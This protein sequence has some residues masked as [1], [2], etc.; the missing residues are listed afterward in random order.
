MSLA[1]VFPRGGKTSGLLARFGVQGLGHPWFFLLNMDPQLKRWYRYYY[2]ESKLITIVQYQ[3]CNTEYTYRQ[4]D[5]HARQA[6]RQIDRSRSST[7]ISYREISALNVTC[8]FHICITY[9]SEC[10]RWVISR[11]LPALRP[12]WTP[13]QRGLCGR[14]FLAAGVPFYGLLWVWAGPSSAPSFL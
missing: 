4:I 12:M 1:Q 6:G 3:N 7:N 5:R 2:H 13:Q 14:H 8:I 10:W 11:K 9:I